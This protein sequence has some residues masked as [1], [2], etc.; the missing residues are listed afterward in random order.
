MKVIPERSTSIYFLRNNLITNQTFVSNKMKILKRKVIEKSV[1]QT[2]D[3]NNQVLENKRQTNKVLE[4]T[5][6][7]FE[8]A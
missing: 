6:M 8:F 2:I 5:G 4:D 7:L 1:G 3:R